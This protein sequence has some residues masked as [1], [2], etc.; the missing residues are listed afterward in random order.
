[1]LYMLSTILECLEDDLF[2]VVVVVNLIIFYSYYYYYF[3]FPIACRVGT[4]AFHGA[5]DVK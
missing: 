4:H 2:I 3:W 1:M 5:R